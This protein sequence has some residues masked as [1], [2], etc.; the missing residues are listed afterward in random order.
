MIFAKIRICDQVFFRGEPRSFLIF[1]PWTFI[2][3]IVAAR[4][5]AFLNFKGGVG[6]TTDAVNISWTLAFHEL[7]PATRVLVVDLDP[8][9]N[10]SFW[11]MGR[12]RWREADEQHLTT[13]RLFKEHLNGNNPGSISA[14]LVHAVRDH[15]PAGRALDIIPCSMETIHRA[16][17]RR[18]ADHARYQMIISSALAP[19]LN[20]Y[21]YIFL[22]CGPSYNILTENALLAAHYQLVPYTPDY[23]ALEGIKWLGKLTRRLEM[24]A[25]NKPVAQPLGIIVNSFAHLNA[26]ID[27]VNE[28][29]DVVNSMRESGLLP[30]FTTVFEPYIRRATRVTEATHLQRPLLDFAPND[31]VTK[32]FIEVTQEITRY[33][34]SL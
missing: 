27:A 19:L 34:D 5:I 33:I 16:F 11:L 26:S 7:F 25:R 21:D 14:S 8:Q 15:L 6:K 9:C 29:R 3:W 32:D 12:E 20:Q 28:L 18:L 17:D 31:P 30:P 22:D 24:L 4:V 10:T 1:L 13:E 23:L 2:Y